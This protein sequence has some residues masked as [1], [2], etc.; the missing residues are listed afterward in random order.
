MV[1]SLLLLLLLLLLAFGE[2][3]IGD[4]KPASAVAVGD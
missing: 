4:G 2:Y 1:E 3:I